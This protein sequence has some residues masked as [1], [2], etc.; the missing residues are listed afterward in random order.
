MCYTLI[1]QVVVTGLQGS[2]YPDDTPGQKAI[3]E[4]LLG[5][6]VELVLGAGVEYEISTRRGQLRGSGLPPVEI[7]LKIVPLAVKFRSECARLSR[8]KQHG[9]ANVYFNPC[10]TLATRY[11]IKLVFYMRT[12]FYS[13]GYSFRVRVEVLRAIAGRLNSSQINAYCVS[14]GPRP[15]LSVGPAAGYAGRRNSIFY[16]DAIKR[17]G[18]LLEERFLDKAYDRAQQFFIGKELFN[19]TS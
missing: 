8:A 11:S 12:P 3:Y 18:Y 6:L 5:P 19:Q 16:M 14:N 4:A 10:V 2:T 15:K 7:D 1:F 17:Y 9:L 13:I